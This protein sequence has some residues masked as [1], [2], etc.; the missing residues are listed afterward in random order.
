M[1]SELELNAH[2]WLD[3]VGLITALW[4]SMV[5]SSLPEAIM[6]VVK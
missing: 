4:V 3:K 1:E 5:F 6:P 2:A